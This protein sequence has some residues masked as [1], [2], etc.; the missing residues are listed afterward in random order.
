MIKVAVIEAVRSI[1]RWCIDVHIA[2]VIVH[3]VD[4]VVR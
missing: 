4:G 1:G 3:Y 2:K